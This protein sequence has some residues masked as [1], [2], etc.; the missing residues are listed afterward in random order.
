MGV[1]PASLQADDHVVRGLQ[2]ERAVLHIDEDIVEARRREGAGNLGRPVHLQAA[3]VNHLAFGEP[4][5]G[6]IVRM[7]SMLS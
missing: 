1:M 3:A 7:S 6:R 5:P 2:V 4:F